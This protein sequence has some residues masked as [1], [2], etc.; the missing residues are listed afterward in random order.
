MDNTDKLKLAGITVKPVEATT[1][2]KGK[3]CG[4]TLPIE[5]FPIYGKGHRNTCISC[6]RNE[7]GATEKFKQYQ[8]V[9]LIDELRARGYRGKLEKVIVK[10]FNL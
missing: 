2:K 5:D 7:S 9:E 10:S 4:K 3:C 1:Q 8:S 6:L